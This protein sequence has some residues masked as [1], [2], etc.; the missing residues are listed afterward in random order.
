[1]CTSRDLTG[2]N[3][4]LVS[5]RTLKPFESR[6]AESFSDVFGLQVA[7]WCLRRVVEEGESDSTVREVR[8]GLLTVPVY[9][10]RVGDRIVKQILADAISS[11]EFGL[12]ARPA[13]RVPPLSARR[14]PSLPHR[15][16]PHQKDFSQVA[17]V[18]QPMT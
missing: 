15:H 5:R 16:V 10:E 7:E 1:V 4:Y 17:Q 3:L 18:L 9:R 6:N 2:G 12:Q 11:G 8:C 13:A 14:T